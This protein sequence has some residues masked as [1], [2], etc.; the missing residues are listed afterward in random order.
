LTTTVTVCSVFPWVVYALA[1][2]Y[3]KWKKIPIELRFKTIPP[4]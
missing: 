3:N 1:R 2:I 4:D